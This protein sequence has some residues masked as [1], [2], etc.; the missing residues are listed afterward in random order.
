MVGKSS[1]TWD[2]SYGQALKT[3]TFTDAILYLQK[4]L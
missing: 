4:G 3:G 2:S 1:Q